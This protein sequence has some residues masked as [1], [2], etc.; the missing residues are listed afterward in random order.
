MAPPSLVT[1]SRGS[2]PGGACQKSDWQNQWIVFLSLKAVETF[3]F[4]GK[5]AWHHKCLLQR[6][7]F[8]VSGI[9][10]GSDSLITDNRSA[11]RFAEKLTFQNELAALG[12]SESSFDSS[13]AP[14]TT[15]YSLLDIQNF[16]LSPSLSQPTSLSPAPANGS[17]EVV[18][19]PNI[20]VD[21]VSRLAGLN[22]NPGNL[23]FVHQAGATP[24]VGG[25]AHFQTPQDGYRALLDQIH[26]DA[27]R[28]Y[29]LEQYI[30][31]YAP[32]SENDTSLYIAQASQALGVDSSTPLSQI[33]FN[34]LAAFQARKESGTI[35][36]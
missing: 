6:V 4:I 11:Q 14:E 18:E 13:A 16:A 19:T 23:K 7:D 17:E 35:I 31:K 10:P 28:G 22:N 24:G 27:R 33:D 15:A 25:F 3:G 29:T 30:T 20:S 26:L 21:G 2:K 32:P 8:Q 5:S 12:I 9:R 36:G 1:F 34:K